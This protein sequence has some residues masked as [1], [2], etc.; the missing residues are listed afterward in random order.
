MV[1]PGKK[2]AVHDLWGSEIRI[3]TMKKL[4]SYG[5]VDK[6]IRPTPLYGGGGYEYF[7]TEA[8]REALQLNGRSLAAQELVTQ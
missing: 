7:I 1:L 3:S 2:A 6:V 8:G 5:Y 4:E